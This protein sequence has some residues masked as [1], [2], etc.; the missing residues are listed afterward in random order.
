MKK[1][2]GVLASIG[3]VGWLSLPPVMAQ[4]AVPAEKVE[5]VLFVSPTCVHCNK[6][7]REYWDKLQQK[8]KD[9]VHFTMYDITQEGNHLIFM[10]TAKRGEVPTSSISHVIMRTTER[11]PRR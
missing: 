11:N 5:F 1:I 7:K 2:I 3:L 10:E 4:P 9:R 6:L 8:Y